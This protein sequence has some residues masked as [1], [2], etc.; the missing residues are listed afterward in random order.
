MRR[1]RGR[2]SGPTLAVVAAIALA[3]HP[4]LALPRTSSNELFH[5]RYNKTPTGEWS[6]MLSERLKREK[7][8]LRG[9][10]NAV[11]VRS[12]D[13]QKSGLEPQRSFALGPRSAA[14][15]QADI[16]LSRKILERALS[17]RDLHHIM[18]QE[19]ALAA[20]HDA[21]AAKAPAVAPTPVARCPLLC[22][23]RV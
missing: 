16:E 7:I 19:A 15:L 3:V 14:A 17:D 22:C 4:G 1:L 8:Y 18:T 13:C 20:H 6:G 10:A 9:G 23:T 12:L 11:D 5:A 21:T 2:S